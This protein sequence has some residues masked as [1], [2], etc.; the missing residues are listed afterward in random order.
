MARRLPLGSRSSLSPVRRELPH[1]IHPLSERQSIGTVLVG[2]EAVQVT[3]LKPRHPSSGES[4]ML[5]LLLRLRKNGGLCQVQVRA[6]PGGNGITTEAWFGRPRGGAG[7]DVVLADTVSTSYAA[8]E[9][10]A[11]LPGFLWVK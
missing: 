8:F 1:V 9:A 2:K 7:P 6:H 11:G 3:N 10:R 5:H 4:M